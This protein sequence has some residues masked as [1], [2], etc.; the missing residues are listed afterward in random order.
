MLRLK[1]R[2]RQIPNGFRFYLPELKWSAPANFPSFSVVCAAVGSVVK[3]NPYLAQKNQ[4]PTRP[5]AIADWVDFYNATLCAKMGWDD[6]IITD[7]GGSVPKAPPPHQQASLASLRSAAA[8]AKELV[9]GAKTLM[10]WDES[11]EPPVPPEQSLARAIVCSDCPKNEKGDFTTWF[12]VPAAELIRRRIEKAQQRNLT[13]PR[14]E[15]LNLCSACHCPLKLKVHVPLS[16]ITKRLAPEQRARLD[17]RCWI[18]H[19]K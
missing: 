17:P 16:W 11:G 4:W 10:E 15:L 5:E 6:Y 7:A 18:L 9:A 2:Q 8:A 3:S 12:T 1:D 14:D 13:T 19:E